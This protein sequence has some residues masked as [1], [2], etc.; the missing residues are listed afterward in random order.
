MAGLFVVNQLLSVVESPS[1]SSAVSGANHLMEMLLCLSVRHILCHAD[2]A[3]EVWSFTWIEL[4][5]LFP[6]LIRAPCQ[7][8]RRA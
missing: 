6:Y 7:R 4:A 5:P 2:E 3:C 1:A 8:V